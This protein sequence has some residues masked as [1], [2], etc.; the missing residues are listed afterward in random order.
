MNIVLAALMAMVSKIL[1]ASFVEFAIVKAAEILVKK[2]ETK[3]DD[4]FLDK[5]KELLNK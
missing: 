5:I 1:T 3:Y 4:E 2:T